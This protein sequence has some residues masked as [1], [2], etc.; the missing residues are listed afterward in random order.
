MSKL[1]IV[2][3][4]LPVTID[5]KKGELIYFPSAGGLATGLNSLDDS[6]DRKWVGWPGKA[7][8]E[9]WEQEAIRKDL[10]GDGLVPVFLTNKE[11]ENFYGGF[12]NKVIW[13]H[14]HYFTQYTDY[15]HDEYWKAYTKVNRKFADAIGPLI[16]EGDTVWV[17]DYQ[18]MLLPGMI[19]ET[20]PDVAIGFFLHIPFPSY[21]IF[22][23][24]PWR[25]EILKGVLGSD[26]IGFHTFGYMRHFLSAAYRIGGFEHQFGRMEIEGR[27]VN[28]DVYPMGID[29]EKYA[30]HE[31]DKDD[32]NVQ[33]I[34]NIS[35][36]LRI[37]LSVD[38][39]DYT[40]GIPQ[41][42][43]AIGRF[44]ASHPE[45]TRQVSFV[46]L[47]VPSR[48]SVD[49][50]QELKHEVET[51]VGE[52]N[53]MHG[54]FDWTPIKYFYRSLSFGSLNALYQRS[55][56]ALITPLRD[57]MNLVAKEYI[58]SKEK[59]MRGVLILSE[60]AGAA[61]ELTDAITVN[62]Q[63]SEEMV[64]ALD[65]ALS[66]SVEEQELRLSKMQERLRKYDV[67]NWA[68]AFMK[69]LKKLTMPAESNKVNLID[70]EV[71]TTM[72]EDYRKS[73]NRLLMLDYDGT[74]MGFQ[75]DP[76]A[77]FPDPELLEL[78]E[79][80]A[81]AEGNTLIINSGRD[82][83][84]LEKWL[85]HLGTDMAAEHGVWQRRNGKWHQAPGMTNTWK[86]RVMEVL[87]GMVERTPGSFIEEKEYSLAWH[88]RKADKELGAKRVREFREVLSY[89]TSNLDLQVL[90]GHKVVEIKNAG[91]NKGK[92]AASWVEENNFDFAIT[93]GD[94]HTDEDTFKAMPEGAYTIKVGQGATEAKYQ[95]E[96]VDKVR[97]LLTMLANSNKP[98][99]A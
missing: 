41:R 21:E 86:E 27:K 24:L 49:Q 2:S 64:K 51:L 95:V 75:T 23:I 87:D 74:L 88:Y 45:Y 22:R 42:I 9:E 35:R 93:I 67:S 7:I 60:M 46:M 66:M 65:Q 8:K 63:D 98:K 62:P 76:Q 31:P 20:H 55:D 34:M 71:M 18:L 1:I 13:P 89:L 52:V 25:E 15:T 33:A 70:S 29:Y 4:R 48:D 47:V 28:V 80:L 85:G 36:G 57:G 43:R 3:N 69:D 37:V 26:L 11:I 97:K 10:K 44:L 83:I 53:G 99:E 79:V 32:D 78:L 94:D 6:L 40:K 73:T 12:S 90:E 54:T 50:Y 72:M 30:F 59:S 56:V 91:V 92:A 5:R 19:R 77:V 16:E 68:A 39:L 14:F 61:N 84:T 81:K 17:H 82:H 38:R 58:A 96:N